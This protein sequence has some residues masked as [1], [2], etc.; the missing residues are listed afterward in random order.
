M[1]SG[2]RSQVASHRRWFIEGTVPSLEIWLLKWGGHLQEVD[3]KQGLKVIRCCITC[4]NAKQWKTYE[5]WQQNRCTVMCHSKLALNK[6]LWDYWLC[7]NIYTSMLPYLWPL[8]HHKTWFMP[9]FRRLC[10]SVQPKKDAES[11]C[12]HRNRTIRARM[13]MESAHGHS[14]T[15]YIRCD[16]QISWLYIHRLKNIISQ[17][18][19]ILFPLSLYTNYQGC[20]MSSWIRIILLSKYQYKFCILNHMQIYAN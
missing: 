17:C 3:A 9:A 14:K 15:I 4:L 6:G 5:E 11:I 18:P 12:C 10:V 8:E 19:V 1:A 13:H 7:L 2:L 20:P 16:M